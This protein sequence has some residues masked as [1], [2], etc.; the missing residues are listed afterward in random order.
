MTAYK[1][2]DDMAIHKTTP[3]SKGLNPTEAI[4]LRDRPAP[5]RNKVSVNPALAMV[6]KYGLTTAIAGI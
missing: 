5:I 4:T 2:V 1:A 6:I 3:C